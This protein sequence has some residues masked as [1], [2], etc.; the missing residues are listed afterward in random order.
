MP[1]S[2]ESDEKMTYGQ[3]NYSPK[4]NNGMRPSYEKSNS[5]RTSNTGALLSPTRKSN[6]SSNT[7]TFVYVESHKEMTFGQ[8]DYGPKSNIGMRLSYDKSNSRPTPNAG[9]ML[10]STRKSKPSS[11]TKPFVYVKSHEEMTCDQSHFGPQSENRNASTHRQV[12]API[13]HQTCLPNDLRPVELQPQIE[14]RNASI[15]RQVQFQTHIEHRRDAF[16]HR[17]VQAVIEHQTSLQ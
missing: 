5:K 6:P 7:K 13:E 2:D 15:L 9:E 3:S 11:N 14:H 4:S 10:S 1:F 17:Q 8:S 12:Q 16:I